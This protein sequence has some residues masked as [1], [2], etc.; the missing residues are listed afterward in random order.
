MT[1]P[2]LPSIDELHA[3]TLHQ[4]DALLHK[5]VH[6]KLLSGS[7]NHDTDLKPAERRRA[8]EGRVMEAAGHANL[9]KGQSLLGQAERSKASKK[10]RV[11]LERKKHEREKKDLEEVGL[12][13]SLLTLLAID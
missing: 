3:R 5:L 2:I 10:V 9:G 12:A 4:N 11:G 8:L 7:L 1:L 6:T 13:L